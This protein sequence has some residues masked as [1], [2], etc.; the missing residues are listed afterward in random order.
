MIHF[1]LDKKKGQL[2]EIEHLMSLDSFWND[3]KRARRFIQISNNLKSIIENYT[4][5]MTHISNFKDELDLLKEEYSEE[6]HKLIE[7]R[8]KTM[9]FK[10]KAYDQLLEWKEKYADKYAVFR[11]VKNILSAVARSVGTQNQLPQY[12]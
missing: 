2:K 7:D 11:A 9:Y 1:E 8:R 10:R 5:L 4:N 12:L 6:M 3:Q